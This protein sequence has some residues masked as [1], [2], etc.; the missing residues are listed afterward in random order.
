MERKSQCGYALLTV[1]IAVAILL[2]MATLGLAQ[3]RGA[4]RVARLDSTSS[5]AYYHAVS[6]LN[7]AWERIPG[8]TPLPATSD[9]SVP[10]GAADADAQLTPTESQGFNQRA[11]VFYPIS[12]VCNPTRDPFTQAALATGYVVPAKHYHIRYV[13]FD[14]EGLE[15]AASPVASVSIAA[16]EVPAYRVPAMP[17]NALGYL[18][19]VAATSTADAPTDLAAYSQV[20]ETGDPSTGTPAET[21]SC[22]E[23]M[24]NWHCLIIDPS[25]L[26]GRAKPGATNQTQKMHAIVAKGWD[27]PEAQPASVRVLKA[28]VAPDGTIRLVG[29]SW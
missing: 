12:A 24:E 9:C 2:A 26:T 18:V 7:R 17:E 8:M 15:T 20:Y 4:V 11:W 28:L 29:H 19:Y 3:V 23:P 10:S 5:T 21:V 13:W 6:A 14:S 1:L 25:T 22:D 27:G 16:D